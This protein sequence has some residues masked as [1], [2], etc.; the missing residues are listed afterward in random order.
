MSVAPWSFS[1]IKAFEQCP[2]QFYHEKVLKQYPV[3]ETDAMMYGTDFHKACEDFIA[4]GTP[5]PEKYSFIKNT[6]NK[7]N[8]MEGDK[9][10]EHKMGLTADL[11]PC[12][13]FAGDASARSR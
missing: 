13:F 5:I 3:V 8:A 1:R 2:K 4:K 12:T 6:M 10:C 11:E 9:L 7:F